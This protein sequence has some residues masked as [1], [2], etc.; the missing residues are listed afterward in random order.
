MCLKPCNRP[1]RTH[2]E[3]IEA[4]VPGVSPQEELKETVDLVKDYV[5]TLDVGQLLPPPA[6][7]EIALHL[8]PSGLGDTS[9]GTPSH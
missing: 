9:L 8:A 7:S 5:I 3:I 1:V 2:A 6:V 4:F